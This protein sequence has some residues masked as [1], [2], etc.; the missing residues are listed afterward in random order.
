MAAVPRP[1]QPSPQPDPAAPPAAAGPYRAARVERTGASAGLRRAT[2]AAS[3]AQATPPGAPS[4]CAAAAPRPRPRPA[5]RPG[6]HG[7]RATTMTA[8]ASLPAGAGRAAARGKAAPTLGRAAGPEERHT[9]G[10]VA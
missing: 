8:V 5:V 7:A 6:R 4:A 9:T 10:E 2:A 3:G 1:P